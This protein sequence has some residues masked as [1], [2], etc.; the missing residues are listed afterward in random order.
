MRDEISEERSGAKRARKA[1]LQLDKRLERLRS[2]IESTLECGMGKWCSLIRA[3]HIP[4]DAPVLLPL[5]G[6]EDIKNYLRRM[7]LPDPAIN[8][9]RFIGLWRDVQK[10]ARH[11]D[12]F[13]KRAIKGMVG[14]WVK[15]P[16][17]FWRRGG[18]EYV[19]KR[20]FTEFSAEKL[21]VSD[22]ETTIA[23]IMQRLDNGT[24]NI[25]R[26]KGGCPAVREAVNRVRKNRKQK[27]QCDA[28]L[29][30]HITASPPSVE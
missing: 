26:F 14:L 13:V 2:E 5:P 12:Q 17:Q 3:A 4:W 15:N 9:E 6:D 18:A 16:H 19:L 11:E 21:R 24:R 22:I 28:F 1:L 29:A 30:Q 8:L 23:G 10:L 7:H 27:Q 25:D 20:I